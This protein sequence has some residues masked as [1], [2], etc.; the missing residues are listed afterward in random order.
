MKKIGLFLLLL[1]VPIFVHA[2]VDYEITDYYISSEIEIAG[3][4]KIKELIVLDGTFNGYQR[5][6]VFKN[7]SL[8]QWEAGNIN[9]EKSSIY[10]GNSLEN[11]KVATFKVGDK[12]DFKTMQDI[13]SN[14]FAEEVSNASLGDKNVYTIEKTADGENVKM[15]SPSNNGR[16]GF[17]LEYVITN[18]V[19]MHNDVA[20]L[21]YPYV[22]DKFDDPI[23]NVQLQVLLP[24]ADTSDN[25][26]IWAHGPLT[27]EVNK[28]QNK[29]KEPIGLLATTKNLNANTGFDIRLTFDKSLIQIPDFMNHSN[30]DALD[31]II[32]VEEKR[33]D[34]ANAQRAK[35]KMIYYS[36][37]GI[38]IA[39]LIGL[40]IL[41]IYIYLK[42]DK[43]YKSDFKG[44]YYRDF[45]EDYDV[46]VIDYLLHKSITS[47]AMSA[48]I[49]NLIYKKNIE[50]EEIKDDKKKKEYKFILKNKNNLS[51]AESY[52]VEFLFTSVGDTH[53]F[54]TKDLKEY[55]AASHTYSLFTAKYGNWKNKVIAEGQN[56][57]FYENKDKIKKLGISYFILGILIFFIG[58]ANNV[59]S[60]ILYLMLIPIIAFLV[61]TTTFNKRTKKGNDDYAKW[62][63][64]KNFLNDF[65]TFDTKEL[66]EIALWERYMVYAVI[67]GI[68]DKVQKA[69]NVKIQEYDP[70][71]PT[72]APY[73]N[74]WVYYDMHYHLA[75]TVSHAITTSINAANAHSVSSSGGG[76]GGGFSSGSG[77]G[78]GGGGGGHGF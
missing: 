46:E 7:S 38:V 72:Y 70:S 54:T 29:D 31:K 73:I 47:N 52:L 24:F 56:Q 18:A 28:Y 14:S 19:V 13:N 75:N 9:F 50:A 77:G 35:I 8:P 78:F 55:A 61:Y 58:F 63:G 69:M 44:K 45:I 40:G 27:G 76:Y 48:S 12:V 64:F 71:N 5:D 42:H 68:A 25:F 11:L 17:Y 2:E 51:E 37:I 21:Y 39:Y 6:I 33:A 26:R 66:P 34:E 36:V 43:E 3:G 53:E 1:L 15:F 10:G 57:N 16:V 67:F 20:E 65:G 62:M 32:A 41:W 30:E 59:V 60:P 49:M 22:G 4:I 74:S 23:K